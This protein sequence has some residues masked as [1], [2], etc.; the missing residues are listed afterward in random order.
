M[1]KAM[2]NDVMEKKAM[3][4]P[5]KKIRVK[6]KYCGGEYWAYSRISK[7]GCPKYECSLLAEREQLDYHNRIVLRRY[8]RRGKK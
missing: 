8:K 5:T 6:C 1:C 3:T 7:F 2:G 4:I